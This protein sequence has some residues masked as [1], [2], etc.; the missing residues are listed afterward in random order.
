MPTLAMMVV[1]LTDQQLSMLVQSSGAAAIVKCADN[2]QRSTVN[3]S[4][5]AAGR[6]GMK[7]GELRRLPGLPY[8][9]SQQDVLQWACTA[10]SWRRL[11]VQ[12][13]R[14]RRSRR[15]C[16]RHLWRRCSFIVLPE[17]PS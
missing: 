3:R 6:A 7:T 8:V 16:L 13:H 17:R 5:L 14:M 4:L 12:V 11:R 1:V 15:H 10:V 9:V 2:K